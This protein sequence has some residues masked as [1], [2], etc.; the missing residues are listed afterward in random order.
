MRR[1][2][3]EVTDPATIRAILEECDVCHLGLVD[4]GR[5]YVVPLNFGY[6]L[7]DGELTLYFHCAKQGRK[8]DILRKNPQVS[9]AIDRPYRLITGPNACDYTMTFGSVLG[10]GTARIVED[11]AE[12]RAMLFCLMRKFTREELPL[13]EK[14]LTG[15]TVIEVKAFSFTAKKNG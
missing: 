1:R 2:E 10:E 9:F 5:A 13:P 8:L 7:E 12:K 4:D 3:R 14:N 11:P 15:V 6:S